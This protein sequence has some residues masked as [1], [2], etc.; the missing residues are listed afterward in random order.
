MVHPYSW[1]SASLHYIHEPEFMHRSVI[2]NFIIL[3]HHVKGLNQSIKIYFLSNR[4]ITVYI[5]YAIAQKA[6]REAYTH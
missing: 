1:K 3:D 2:P 6:A 5:V 4:N